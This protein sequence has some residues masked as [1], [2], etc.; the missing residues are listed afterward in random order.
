MQ[1]ALLVAYQSAARRRRIS[2][3][4]SPH[5]R[6]FDYFVVVGRGA[7]HLEATYFARSTGP[8]DLIFAP[9]AVDSVPFEPWPNTPLPDNV[10]L[11]A[12]PR[13][14]R[15]AAS[16]S[17]EVPTSTCLH[18]VL[19][20]TDGNKLYCTSVVQ[21]RLMTPP[22]VRGACKSVYTMTPLVVSCAGPRGHRSCR[23]WRR[24]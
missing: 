13:G 15:L 17:P 21:W 20:S 6:L 4:P 8:T 5:H 22:E 12:F 9:Q 11:F 19:A 24:G 10:A 16:T 1:A 18:F 14:L 23:C 2:R 3:R 7:L